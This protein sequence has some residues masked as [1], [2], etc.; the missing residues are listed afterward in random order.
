MILSDIIDDAQRLAQD[1]DLFRA[2]DTYARATMVRF[3][4]ETLRQTTLIRPD[5]FTVLGDIATV[6]S[7]VEQQLP[8]DS[9]RMVSIRSIK[10]GAP[11]VEVSYEMMDRSY[12]AWRVD[13]PGVPVNYMRNVRNPNA[14][15]LYPRPQANIVLTGEYVK[16]PRQ[17]EYTDTVDIVPDTYRP[18]LVAGVVARIADIENTTR[19]PERARNF[20][21]M[22][23]Q[24]LDTNLV[25]R[26]ITDTKMAGME[27]GEVI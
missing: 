26:K 20:M 21:Q 27:S 3:A 1:N 22:Y 7:V 23:A 24:L 17:Y 9:M 5:L 25:V 12:P 11:V 15:F 16:T 14:Y 18:A 2:P 6:P 4:N 8:S 19:D 10:S 13:A